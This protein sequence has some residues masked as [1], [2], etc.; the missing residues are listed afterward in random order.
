[1]E[2]LER[3]GNTARLKIGEVA[4]KAGVGVESLRFYESRGL[5]EPIGRTLSGYRLYDPAVF[6]RLSF[7][8]KS[9][10]VGF[11]LDEIAWIIAEARQGRRPC[12]EVRQMAAA[13]LGELDQR[14][15]EMERYRNELRETVRAWERQGEAEGVICGLIEGL[16]P[17]LPSRPPSRRGPDAVPN[18]VASRRKRQKRS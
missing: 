10:A 4:K 16:E 12:A 5:I 6:E 11:S 13:R 7:I 18:R 15:A 9:Q 1:M 17:G 8:R 3:S 2:A 14:L